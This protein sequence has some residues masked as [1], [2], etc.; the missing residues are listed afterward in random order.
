MILKKST[1]NTKT[2][3]IKIY[4]KQQKLL[5]KQNQNQKKYFNIMNN[6]LNFSSYMKITTGLI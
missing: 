3:R 1:P 4:N 5:K 2:S 6:K